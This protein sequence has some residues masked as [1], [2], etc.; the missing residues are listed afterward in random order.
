VGNFTLITNT[1]G[2]SNVAVGL[3]V[4]LNNTTG[5]ANDAYGWQSL[6]H[7]TTGSNNTAVGDDTM[8][9]NTTG[10]NNTVVGSMA[11]FNLTTGSNN[12]LIGGY[13]GTA[14]MAGNVALST[15]DGTVRLQ[16][17]GTNWTSATPI[18]MTGLILP[19]T[20]SPI[21]LNGSVGTA[22][23]MLTSAGA[24]ATPTWSTPTSDLDTL[25]DVVITTPTSKD[26]LIY[27]G[28]S[29]VNSRPVMFENDITITADYTITT[30]KN[31][32]SA[33][34]VTIAN[35]VTVTVPDGSTWSVV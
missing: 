19:S 30:G 29:W 8:W 3:E 7:N 21:T 6:Y 34:P 24:G 11:G 22:G 14:G 5:G 32:M 25:T 33:G 31:A 2:S 4:L 9:N 35:G 23:Q 10:S 16:H 17:D 20:T 28:T 1:T 13:Q 27:N 12:T 18:S 26:Q 15:G